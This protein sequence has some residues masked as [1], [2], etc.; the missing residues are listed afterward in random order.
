MRLF[1]DF[2]AAASARNCAARQK[3]QRNK[4]CKR[5]APGPFGVRALF[6]QK[7]SV[8][9]LDCWPF[10]KIAPPSSWPRSR[11]VRTSVPSAAVPNIAIIIRAPAASS[12]VMKPAAISRRL[13]RCPLP[14]SGQPCRERIGGPPAATI[15]LSKVK[16]PVPDRT[17]PASVRPNCLTSSD[18][19]SGIAF[20]GVPV[21]WLS[22]RS[23]KID[24]CRATTSMAR[25]AGPALQRG[26]RVEQRPG[27]IGK[28]E[29]REL[30]DKAVILRLGRNDRHRHAHRNRFHGARDV[31][32]NQRR[33]HGDGQAGHRGRE[34]K[35]VGLAVTL[36][37]P[38]PAAM[39]ALIGIAG[40]C[41]SNDPDESPLRHGN[42]QAKTVA[43]GCK[44]R[45]GVVSAIRSTPSGMVSSPSIARS[46]VSLTCFE[47]E[48]MAGSTVVTS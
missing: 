40:F 20:G 25:S 12:C 34:V 31:R 22:I 9:L 15:E 13:G 39:L 21:S 37:S 18:R 1:T 45:C 5:N 11:E 47:F 28:L 43:R 35:T 38:G 44:E 29:A 26:G 46:A 19:S 14:A 2:M 6:G 7:R 17:A 32:R 30:Q 48:P 10:T 27:R 24:L 8:P 41:S 3:A 33:Q 42:R 23:R 36:V 16:A 4:A